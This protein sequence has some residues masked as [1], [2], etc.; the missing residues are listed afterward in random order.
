MEVEITDRDSGE[1]TVYELSRKNWRSHWAAMRDG[2]VI[3]WIPENEC[4]P[5]HM[6]TSG[7]VWKSL[8]E[9]MTDEKTV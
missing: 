7:R 1:T 9:E 5:F 3:M 4:P 6:I 8:T 2:L